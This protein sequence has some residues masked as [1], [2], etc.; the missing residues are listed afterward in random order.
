MLDYISHCFTSFLFLVEWSKSHC[1]KIF[2]T[3]PPVVKHSTTGFP[4]SVRI[5]YF[6]EMYKTVKINATQVLN[7]TVFVPTLYAPNLHPPS[8][9]QLLG[10]TRQRQIF[11]TQSV[12]VGLNR[13]TDTW[14]N[15]PR[16]FEMKCTLDSELARPSTLAFVAIP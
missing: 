14:R 3:Y 10:C 7:I 11:R 12:T 5:L 15:Y 16:W 2:E 4:F 6:D 8:W 9:W 1:N 13:Q